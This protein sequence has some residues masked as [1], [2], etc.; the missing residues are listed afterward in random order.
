MAQL[1]SA[2]F[3]TMAALAAAGFIAAMLRGEWARIEAVLN[4][5]A[6]EQARLRSNLPV[7]VRLRAWNRAEA[8]QAL[9]TL[10]AAA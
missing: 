7:R 1:F 5:T 2:L 8:R 6:I 4:G 9:P 10:R 3:F